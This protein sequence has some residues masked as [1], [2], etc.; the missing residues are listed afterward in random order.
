LRADVTCAASLWGVT[1]RLGTPVNGTRPLRLQQALAGGWLASA[2]PAQRGFLRPHQ[3]KQSAWPLLHC[4][5]S[6]HPHCMSHMPP[7][8]LCARWGHERAGA[9]EVTG[10]SI[11]PGATSA[12][13]GPRVAHAS[14][15]SA[16][17]HAMWIISPACWRVLVEARAAACRTSCCLHS[18]GCSPAHPLRIAAQLPAVGSARPARCL[19]HGGTHG[20]G[21]P[22][23][24]LSC[25]QFTALNRLGTPRAAAPVK[26]SWPSIAGNCSCLR[27]RSMA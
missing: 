26:T 5:P 3:H 22:G 15:A 27:V 1:G 12:G 21:L 16:L 24:W 11:P 25:G 23:G 6:R 13:C 9:R 2:A 7:M 4:S 20:T 18:K 10:Q 14:P 8:Q 17:A 19:L